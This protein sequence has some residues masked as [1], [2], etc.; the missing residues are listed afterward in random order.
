MKIVLIGS[1]ASG[2][3]TVGKAL[4]AR[5]G[6]PYLDVDDGI[7]EREGDHLAGIYTTRG[8]T[9]FRQVE[10]EIARDVMKRDQRVI[11][12]GAGTI[13][14]PA[15]RDLIDENTFVVYLEVP[16][17][18]LWD[19][20]QADPESATRRPPLR[21][22][23]WAEVEEILAVRGPVYEDAADLVVDGTKDPEELVTEIADA[24]ERKKGAE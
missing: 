2:K 20:I 18:V 12:Y 10:T 23:G 11:T 6:W 1:R 3:S 5:L 7:E 8:N 17:G 21:S 19:R 24:A 13:M 16:P 15:N 22:G 9:Y 14:T 4:A